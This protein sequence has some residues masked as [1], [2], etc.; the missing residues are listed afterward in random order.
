MRDV[1]KVLAGLVVLGILSGCR[2]EA[3]DPLPAAEE[4][5]AAEETPRDEAPGEEAPAQ[6]LADPI[7][8]VTKPLQEVGK[9]LA[10][11]GAGPAVEEPSKEEPAVE[12]GIPVAKPVPDKPGFVVSP[13]SGKWVDVRGIPAGTL[14]A[15]PHKPDEEGRKQ[16]FRVPEVPEAPAAVAPAGEGPE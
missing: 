14:V 3:V 16:V 6:P 11:D 7:K 5:A 13:Y 2:R 9:V 10:G 12:A 4:A 8:E 1:R 15:D